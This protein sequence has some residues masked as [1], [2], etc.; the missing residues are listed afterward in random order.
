[1]YRYVG[2]VWNPEDPTA[3]GAAIQYSSQIEELSQWR[4]RLRL[5]GLMV[6]DQL[7]Q[8]PGLTSYVLPNEAGIILGRL[9]PRDLN[10]WTP[11]W[12]AEIRKD[13]AD[14][15]VVTEGRHLIESYWGGYVAFLLDHYRGRRY[16]IRD[17]SGRIPC[18]RTE[19]A[20]V[21]IVFADAEDLDRL[22]LPPRTVNWRYI[23]AFIYYSQLQIRETGINEVTELLSGDCL[24]VKAESHNQV[25]LWDPRRFCADNVIEDGSEAARQLRETTQQCIS[26]WA[27]IYGNV[28]LSLS[29]GFDSAVVLGCLARSP[30]RPLVTCVNRFSDEWAGD[31][32]YF[33][34]IAAS[35]AS[36]ELIELPWLASRNQID[37]RLMNTPK[38]LKPHVSGII[39]HLDVA[40]RN[41]IV[42]RVAADTYWTGEGGDHIFFQMKSLLGLADY[43][44]THGF[45]RQVLRIAGDTARLL[46]ISYWHALRGGLTEAMSTAT[47]L[48]NVELKGGGGFMTP[49]ALDGQSIEYIRHP[50]MEKSGHLLKGKQYQIQFLSEVLNRE[51]PLGGTGYAESQHPLLS[52]P[53]LELCLRIPIYVLLTGGRQRGLARAAF[54][55]TVP[56]QIIER[57]TKGSTTQHTL[58]ILRAS[59]PY[60]SKLL[61]DG[62]LVRE[63]ILSRKALEP[64]VTHKK[65][66]RVEQIF[67]LLSSITAEIWVRTL[68]GSASA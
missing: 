18:Y 36:A 57:E 31:E 25:S 44:R 14:E 60:I 35:R 63:G 56:S 26:A 38:I 11:T 46:R 54:A 19:S 32:R 62:V 33:A 39:G 64:H 37:D 16:V 21:E 20:G 42:T 52:Q 4:R 53:L 51:R 28:L 7:Y 29:G 47:P 49:E 50:W 68:P 41:E 55:D 23:T 10:H 2:L 17:C 48:S 3:S 66:I 45:G 5:P 58:G 67:P 12:R 15:I 59:Q 22:S 9:F 24:V 13:E 61:L 34:R 40:M 27:S 6:F 43:I 30:T 8:S 1:M 65:P